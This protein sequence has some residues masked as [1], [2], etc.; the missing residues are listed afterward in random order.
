LDT[1]YC[2]EQLKKQEDSSKRK[3]VKEEEAGSGKS[4][5]DIVNSGSASDYQIYIPLG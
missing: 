3:V 4:S 5:K 1:S 2:K